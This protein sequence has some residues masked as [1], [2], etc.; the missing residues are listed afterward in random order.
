MTPKYDKF[1]SVAVFDMK[2]N[3][4][5]VVRNPDKP[6]L[7][8]RPG[9]K[10]PEGDFIVVNLE[11]DQGLAFTRM[12]VAS[13]LDEVKK[14]RKDISLEGGAGDMH[15][16]VQKFSPEVEKKALT[17]LDTLT[18]VVTPD[19]MFGQK[20]GDV[21][22]LCLAAGV[23][24]GQ[25]G[26]PAGTVRYNVAQKDSNGEFLDGKNTYVVTTPA[27][28]VEK[29]GYFSVTVYGTDNKLLIPNDKKI[30]AMTSDNAKANDDGT[31]T[32]TLS[33]DGEG[34]NGI[35]TSGK[36]F[37]AVIRAYVPT[38]KVDLYQTKIEKQR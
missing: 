36:P 29:S 27:N 34:K 19:V 32:V 13:N 25:L 38:P 22:E 18:T 7:I 4:P 1:F 24:I 31:Y 9:Q 5:L 3:V 30:Y 16:D 8:I 17:V 12:V 26:T 35:P 14:L 6:I 10:A 37:Y 11:T 23:R 20:S 33:P 15:R 2:H 28:M 21:G